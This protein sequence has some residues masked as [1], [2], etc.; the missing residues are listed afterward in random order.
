METIMNFSVLMSIYRN[1]KP[2][3]VMLAIESITTQQ[4][5]KP[6]EVILVVDG[7]VST[8]LT[9]LINNY[10]DANDYHFNIIELPENKGLGNAL[11]VGL[12]KTSFNL[13]AR[14]DSDDIAC[15]DR[16]DKQLA[17][18]KCN[19]GIA[20]VGGQIS[21]FIDKPD[22][23]VAFRSVPLT[24]HEC[25]KYYQDRDPLNHMTVMFRKKAVMDVGSY[26]PWYLDEDTYLWGRLL[27]KGYKLA[28]LPDILVNVRVGNEMYARRGG[29]KYFKSDSKILKWKLEQ[30]LIS[31]SKFIYNYLIRF[32]V[33]VIM[34]NSIRSWIFKNLLRKNTIV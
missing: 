20:V 30:D 6:T 34:P 24:P 16:F 4:T 7:P 12:E 8:E 29:L 10:K 28:N 3:H 11:R 27:K 19:P 22:N 21:E 25:A 18:M 14:M 15:S 31:R 26:Q 9:E 17:F 32:I 5:V 2:A 1:D 13:I 33:Q 23:V